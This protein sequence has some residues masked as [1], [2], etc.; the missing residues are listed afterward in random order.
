MVLSLRSDPLPFIPD[1]VLEFKPFLLGSLGG[2]PLR[3]LG[4]W[5]S[6]DRS[7]VTMSAEFLS[8][9]S[10]M[11]RNRSTHPHITP[12]IHHWRATHSHSQH[13]TGRFLFYFRKSLH[14]FQL[15][16]T[17]SHRASNPDFCSRTTEKLTSWHPKSN[18]R[19]SRTERRSKNTLGSRFQDWAP[20]KERIFDLESFFSLGSV[21]SWQTGGV[22]KPLLVEE[23]PGM[24]SFTNTWT[25]KKEDR[26]KSRQWG[27][28][29][30]RPSS[31]DQYK[32]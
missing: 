10:M 4:E 13:W 2:D 5:R 17:F 16:N 7:D 29:E 11:M 6:R 21:L 8:V 22:V 23:Y 20:S 30:S 3:L 27:S 12:Q 26:S 1:L 19:S 28:V 9:I 31:L 25:G 14:L 32:R 24:N 18:W 15:G